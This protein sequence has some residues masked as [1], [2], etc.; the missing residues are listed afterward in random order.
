MFEN[1]FLGHK[2][3][4]VPLIVDKNASNQMNPITPQTADD[5][6]SDGETTKIHNHDLKM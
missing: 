4:L 2:N 5:S 1:I 6:G 3:P